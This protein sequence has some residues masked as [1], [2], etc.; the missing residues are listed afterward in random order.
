MFYSEKPIPLFSKCLLV[1]CYVPGIVLGAGDA[2][3][4]RS[5]PCPQGVLTFYGRVGT[6]TEIKYIISHVIS[7]VEKKIKQ[8]KGRGKGRDLSAF[9]RG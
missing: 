6:Q 9:H 1:A 5:S 8:C 2:A 7:A 3:V 4:N